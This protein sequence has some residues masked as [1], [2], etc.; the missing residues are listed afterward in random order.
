MLTEWI[1]TLGA[2][3]MP[4]SYVGNI[5]LDNWL[6]PWLFLA[7]HYGG[8]FVSGCDALVQ[9]C[10]FLT[11]LDRRGYRIQVRAGLTVLC[12]LGLFGYFMPPD[13]GSTERSIVAVQS[14]LHNS[15]YDAARVDPMAQAEVIKTFEVLTQRAYALN[16]DFVIW[17]ETA[18]RIPVLKDTELANR[19]LPTAAHSST[20]IAGLPIRNGDNIHNAAI[21][22]AKGHAIDQIYKIKLVVGTEDHFS[23]G[24]RHRPLKTPDEAIGIMICLEAV[25]PQIGQILANQGAQF[26]VVMSNDAGFGYSPITHHMTRRAAIRALETGRWLVR[27]GQAGLSVV[28]TPRGEIVNELELFSPSLMSHKVRL[29]TDQ[30]LYV[31][32]PN[33]IAYA[34]LFLLLC[35]VFFAFHRPINSPKP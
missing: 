8:L 34:N 26:L 16:P 19:L 14:G 20:L 15:R 13:L 30:T 29:R 4:A 21:S 32:Q 17:P 28:I 9:S 5:A 3:S 22:I 11:V 25:Y 12:A 24:L 18:V 35:L 23:P 33:L 27:V 10:V 7:P 31:R 6:A 1:R 2:L